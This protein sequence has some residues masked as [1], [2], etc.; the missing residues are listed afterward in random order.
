MMNP[1]RQSAL[2]AYGAIDA[3]SQVASADPYRLIQLL[4][5]NALERIAK[6]K[7]H[8]ERGEIAQ[9]CEQVDKLTR[10]VSELNDSLNLDAG[11]DIA[12][13]LHNAYGYCLMQIVRAH[14]RNEPAAF[15]E[16]A[17][18]LREIKTGWD[19]IAPTARMTFGQ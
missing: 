2:R 4:L 18:V 10:V 3:H 12:V 14:A 19:A 11:G 1:G 13:Q 6:I 15:E 17:R 8:I 16:I 5:G 9:K 7:G